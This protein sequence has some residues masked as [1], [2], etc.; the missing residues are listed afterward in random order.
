MSAGWIAQLEDHPDLLPSEQRANAAARRLTAM[1]RKYAVTERIPPDAL[2]ARQRSSLLALARHAAAE[3]PHFAARLH[4]AGL[5]P[6][7]LAEPG[8]LQ[9][10]PS[11]SRRR[12]VDSAE[13]LFCR[14]TPA[15]HGQV[16][17]TT[18]SGSTGEPVTIRRTQLC[19]LL[20][21]A[22]G[23]R[24]HLWHRRRFDGRLAV[25]RANIDK[26]IE[27]P[28]WGPPVSR[29]FKTGPGAAQ[30]CTCPIHEIIRWI[31][32]YSPHQVLSLPSSL[33]EIIA[34]LERTGQRLPDLAGIR[35]LSETVTPLLRTDARRVFG[36]DVVDNYSSQ[37]GGIMAIQCPE[38]GA[39]H[40]AEHILIEVVIQSSLPVTS[41]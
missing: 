26:A 1:L 19:H 38:A 34:E 40:V 7:K 20:W 4:D 24:E 18:T 31:V 14:Q 41:P 36:V 11:L 29:L 32:E 37:E 22:M 30:P 17:T 3:S 10:L 16:S 9:T 5:T 12:L 27:A 6:E 25:L 33:R 15:R 13:T 28:T 35:T 39:F 2:L 21:E 8:G 23:M